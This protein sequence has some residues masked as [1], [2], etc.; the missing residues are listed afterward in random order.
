MGKLD[1]VKAFSKSLNRYF[2]LSLN[3]IPSLCMTSISA[4]PAAIDAHCHLHDA[5]F[6]PKRAAAAH[7]QTVQNVVARSRAMNV[8][9]V[10]SCAC[11]EADWHALDTLREQQQQL[12]IVPAFGLHPWW[13]GDLDADACLLQRLRAKLEQQPKAC[14]RSAVGWSV[15]G[16]E[17]THS[18]LVC[19]CS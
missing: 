6:N 9:H 3:T 2:V 11:F 13:A 8:S 15:K 1:L 12:P 7:D 4:P 16:G 19:N 14:V 5:R 10:V 18:C 17:L